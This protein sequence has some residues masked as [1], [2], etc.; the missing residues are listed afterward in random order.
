MKRAI[1]RH[2][3]Q[4]LKRNR[5][6]YW[7]VDLTPREIGMVV[8]TPHPCSC[9]GGCGHQRKVYGPTVQEKRFSEVIS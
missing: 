4:R 5:R 8:T 9:A 3:Y 7:H 2:H 1:R 6:A